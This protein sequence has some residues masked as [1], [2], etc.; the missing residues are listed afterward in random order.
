MASKL[1]SR[2]LKKTA[3]EM[4]RSL[5]GSEMCIR[6]RLLGMPFCAILGRAFAD[7]MVEL[8]I[9]GGETMNVPKDEIVDKLVELVR[10]R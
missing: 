10:G 5:V 7:G 9:R 1:P 6:D 2:S 4:L 8:R 3:Y